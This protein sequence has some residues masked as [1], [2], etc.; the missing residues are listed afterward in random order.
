MQTHRHFPSRSP[1]TTIEGALLL[2]F[3]VTVLLAG[4]ASALVVV[5]QARSAAV[6]STKSANLVFYM[7]SLSVLWVVEACLRCTPQNLQLLET[8]CLELS[9]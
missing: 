9:E 4:V 7:D 1:V 5:V 8:L 3:H 2:S 6:A